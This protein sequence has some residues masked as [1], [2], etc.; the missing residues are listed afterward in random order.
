MKNKQPARLEK[1]EDEIEQI[2]SFLNGSVVV[3]VKYYIVLTIFMILLFILMWIVKGP[4][5]GY[6]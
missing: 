6:L 1:Q 2:K 4:T 3:R 5:Y